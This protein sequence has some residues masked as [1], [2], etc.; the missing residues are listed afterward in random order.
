M[1][2]VLEKELD[3]LEQDKAQVQIVQK[4]IL[5]REECIK[6]IMRTDEEE[7]Q[8]VAALALE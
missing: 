6:I 5:A 3:E 4:A 1:S 7:K 8:R 2:R